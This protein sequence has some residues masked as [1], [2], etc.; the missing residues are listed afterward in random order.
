MDAAAID[1]GP[2]RVDSG[3]TPTDSGPI[4]TDSAATDSEPIDSGP[5]VLP[6]SC[7]LGVHTTCSGSQTC[8]LGCSPSGEARCAEMVPSNVERSYWSAGAQDVEVLA[9]TSGPLV[10]DTSECNATFASSDTATQNSGGGEVCVLMV[11]DLLVRSGGGL[12]VVGSRPLVIMATGDVILEPNAYIDVS[13]R[14]T[15]PGPGGGTAGGASDPNGGGPS[16]GLAGVHVPSF[17]DGGGGGGAFC[18]SGGP[19]GSGGTAPGGAPGAAIAHAM[20]MPLA[21]GSGGGAGPGASFSSGTNEASGGAG[22]GALQISS[23]R[24]IRIDGLV[25]AGG[26]GGRGGGNAASVN[27]GAGGG[28]GSG[29]AV[30]LEAP[31][32]LVDSANASITTSGGA[33]GGGASQSNPGGAGADGA[34]TLGSAIGGTAGGTQAGASGGASGGGSTLTG[35][36]GASNANAT[37]NGGG[38]GGGVGCV[39]YRT[40]DGTLPAGADS[41]TSGNVD[42]ALRS[43]SLQLL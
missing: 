40:L 26:G 43:A 3:P 10:F 30:L 11:N 14:G 17:D 34:T 24:S 28:G 35:E 31:V 32:I 1:A 38:G 25:L 27:W 23:L 29:G 41:R 12:R 7:E 4:P 36:A 2:T 8:P 42:P 9:S 22:G 18:G 16:G 5:C 15:T 19:G 37:G 21:G 20:L 6:A 13:A 33:G 39:V